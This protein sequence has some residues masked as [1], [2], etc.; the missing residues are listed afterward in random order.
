MS[1]DLSLINTMTDPIW[2]F[3]TSFFG[4][5]G[6]MAAYTSLVWW[7]DRYEREPLRLL[8]FLFLCGAIPCAGIAL[9]AH[10]TLSFLATRSLPLLINEPVSVV[11]LAPLIEETIK[12]LPILLIRNHNDFN[13]PTDGIVYGSAVG[14][15][16]AMTENL[17]YFLDSFYTWG[18]FNWLWTMIIRTVFTGMLHAFSTGFAG[19]ML[20]R[21]KY[22]HARHRTS[23]AAGLAVAILFHMSWNSTMFLA[24]SLELSRYLYFFFGCFPALIVVM[25]LLMQFS[26]FEESVIIREELAAEA[27]TGLITAKQFGIIPYY[28]K[29]VA[30]HWISP[31]IKR[32]FLNCATKLAFKKRELKYMNAM[33]LDPARC[34]IEE[35]RNRLR[36]L[37][38]ESGT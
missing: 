37:A 22:H 28:H 11:V 2:I 9:I 1:G 35:L 33:E 5:F 17:F 38:R 16:F 6:P 25:I 19:Y 13:N 34:E 21:A 26:L 4:A 3:I 7:M 12:F 32:E 27:A 23:M 29:R 14:F 18:P 10:F 30:K 15:G 24:A 20:G 36:A 31:G 8:V